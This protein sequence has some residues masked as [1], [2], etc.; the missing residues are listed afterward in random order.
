MATA[1]T[2]RV[3]IG[4][5]AVNV[6]SGVGT[7]YGIIGKI[8][9]KETFIAR[10]YPVGNKDGYYWQKIYFMNSSGRQATGYCIVSSSLVD[11]HTRRSGTVSSGNYFMRVKK[12]A[13]L[14]GPYSSTEGVYN[15]CG[16]LNTND[17]VVIPSSYSQT[18]Y[19]G[20]YADAHRILGVWE[21]YPYGK[22]VNPS[23]VG[24]VALAGEHK[25]MTVSSTNPCIRGNW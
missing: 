12:S 9:P 3:N 23:N 11:W 24:R 20:N 6:R 13:G 14:Y 1:G 4:T 10:E 22:L 21:N 5:G 7:A 18:H 15:H 19:I 17:V 2:T 16:Y 25:A 8:N